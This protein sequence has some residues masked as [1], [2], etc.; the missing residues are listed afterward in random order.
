ML[1]EAQQM[2]TLTHADLTADH[3]TC[4]LQA[5]GVSLTGDGS[6][7]HHVVLTGLTFQLPPV[8]SH[9]IDSVGLGDGCVPLIVMQTSD[10]GMCVNSLNNIN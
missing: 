9:V 8:M 2:E 6:D 1:T 4:C 10:L 3:V 7:A 5:D